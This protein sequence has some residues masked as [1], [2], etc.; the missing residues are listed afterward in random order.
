MAYKILLW[1]YILNAVLLVN[2]EIA[3]ACW[4]KWERI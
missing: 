3:P 1:I 2:D 4:K